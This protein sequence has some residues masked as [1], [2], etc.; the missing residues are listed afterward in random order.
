MVD[1]SVGCS[2][3]RKGVEYLR[4]MNVLKLQVLVQNLKTARSPSCRLFLFVF[5]WR[6]DGTQDGK[7]RVA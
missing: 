7:A 6:F 1:G 4:F 5:Y 3:K 2:E